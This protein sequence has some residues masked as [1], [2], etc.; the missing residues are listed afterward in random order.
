MSGAGATLTIDPEAKISLLLTATPATGFY[1]VGISKDAH[2][3]QVTLK[4]IAITS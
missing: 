4:N 1:G 3:A 2:E